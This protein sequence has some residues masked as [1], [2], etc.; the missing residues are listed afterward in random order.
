M[1]LSISTL[2]IPWG[3]RKLLRKKEIL[4]AEGNIIS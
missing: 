1:V 4:I 2:I 3:T